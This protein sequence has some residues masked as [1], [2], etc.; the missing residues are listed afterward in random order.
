MS[1]CFCYL[2]WWTLLQ[3]IDISLLATSL[4]YRLP[5]EYPP[6][7]F[8]EVQS[9]D[10]PRARIPLAL[11]LSPSFQGRRRTGKQM[12]SEIDYPDLLSPA[13]TVL[14]RLRF[15]YPL[16]AYSGPAQ[17][18]LAAAYLS[19]PLSP[20]LPSPPEPSHRLVALESKARRRLDVGGRMVS[21]I[22]APLYGMSEVSS[23]GI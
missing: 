4:C 1:V 17:P 7:L 6:P 18:A 15:F 14:P 23:L 13:A 8:S 21:A 9:E 16:A 12:R 11:W 19:L 3:D 5:K 22:G 2:P 20:L 10:L